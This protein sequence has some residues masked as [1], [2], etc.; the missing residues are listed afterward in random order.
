MK[1]EAETER[2]P[3]AEAKVRLI[4]M[5][6]LV[7]VA[8]LVI[9]VRLYAVQIRQGAEFSEKS[10]D[11]FVQ[12]MRLEHDRGEILD[13]EGRL[14][15]TNVPSV[16]IDLTPAF[17]PKTTRLVTR[18]A[19]VANLGERQTE[20]V[21]AALL[22][23]A[24]ERGPPI[25]LARDLSQDKALALR[26]AQ[27]SLE[28]PL[29]AVP[30]IEMPESGDKDR[31]AAFLDPEHFP[32]PL[33][34]IRRLTESMEL[35]APEVDALKKRIAKATGLD[36]YLP[37]IVR[38]DIA[39]E[40]AERVTN[41]VRLGD[42]PGV[43]VRRAKTRHYE[44]EDLAAHLLGYV[45]ELSPQE[46]EEKRDQES[47]TDPRRYRLGDTIGRRGAEKTFEENLRGVDGREAQIVDSKGR[48]QLS[49]LAKQLT[50]EIGIRD[51]PR[52]GDRV[53]LSMDLDLQRVA[54]KAFTGRAGA[55]VMLEVHTG[56]I[57]A[58]TSTP[59]FNPNLVTGYFDPREKRRL[60]DIAELRPWRFRAI[61]D[62]FAPGSTFKAIT[63]I[64]ALVNHAVTENEPINCPGAFHLGSTRFRC[65][66]EAGHG[67][68]VM[69]HAIERSCDVYFYN[70]GAR[71]GLDPIAKVATEMG[72][73]A[74]TG[75]PIDGESPGIIPTPQWYREHADGYTLGAAV[76]AAVGQGATTVTPI[77]L[78]VAYAAIANGGTV[79]EP[80]I[81]LRIE[82]NDG[83]SSVEIP[84]KVRRQVELPKH[85]LDVV[86][87]GLR[88]VVN[89]AG[90]TAYWRRLKDIQVS[91]KT[92]TA[93]VAKLTRGRGVKLD[94]IPYELRDHAWFASYAPSSDPEVVVVCLNEHAGFGG[95]AAAPA[96][97]ATI[98]AWWHKKQERQA[99]LQKEPLTVAVLADDELGASEARSSPWAAEPGG[100][101]HSERDPEDE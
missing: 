28:I 23:A 95:A 96:V 54:E 61:Q 65:F 51:E 98:E 76:N 89:E 56:R 81:G 86:R 66:R 80:Q 25:L 2:E 19:N 77:Q 72:L 20:S 10:R 14:L 43:A 24:D 88:R 27:K 92:G 17:F 59:S 3:G 37:I 62:H 32:T 40:I 93:Q 58:M 63:A 90:G 53:Y 13:R 26:E 21:V 74:R 99:A 91:G 71:L 41:E 36:I 15:V 67:P 1:L 42:L 50:E 33:R 84:P 45:N 78:A 11:N 82:A 97:M 68:L 69:T 6:S 38:R 18:L 7:M 79:F 73:G 47:P 46:L 35:T 8:F 44:N 57:L 83:S 9:L 29:L 30:I 60:L 16:N 34:V 70:L 52:P 75:I 48:P 39:P 12:F 87:E 5:S 100:R 4:I 101:I 94:T 31:Y 22:K 49:H 64:T 85:V 55:L